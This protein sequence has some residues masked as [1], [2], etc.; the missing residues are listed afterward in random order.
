[1]VTAIVRPSFVKHGI[2]IVPQERDGSRMVDTTRRSDKGNPAFRF[3]ATFKVAFINVDDPS[4]AALVIVPAHA[5][6]FGDKAPGKCLSYAVKSAIL[7]ILMLETGE[8]EE[9]RIQPEPEPY[10]EDEEARL[11]NLRADALNGMGALQ[12]AWKAMP[13][14]LRLRLHPQLASLKDAARAADASAKSA[15]GAPSACGGGAGALADRALREAHRIEHAA[16]VLVQEERGPRGGAD[17]PHPGDPGGA[18]HR[19]HGAALRQSGDAVGARAGAGGEGLVRDVHGEFHQPVR[20][21]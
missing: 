2:V 6:D 1:M 5:D 11:T 4:D 18:P 21:L 9:G 20:L 12:T 13:E 16:G 3:E 14:A 7:K 19:I 17:R 8:D 10:N 15:L